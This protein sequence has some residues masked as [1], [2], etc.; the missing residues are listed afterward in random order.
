MLETRVTGV[1]IVCF[2]RELLVLSLNSSCGRIN[3][4]KYVVERQGLG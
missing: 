1:V 4:D 2:F 3:T